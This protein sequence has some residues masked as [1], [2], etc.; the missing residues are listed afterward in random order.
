MLVQK[1]DAFLENQLLL[2][3]QPDQLHNVQ[4]HLIDPTTSE[5]LQLK[6]FFTKQ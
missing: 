2:Q 6:R 4:V 3:F 1:K 5:L